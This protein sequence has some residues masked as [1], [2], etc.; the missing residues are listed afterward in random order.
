M[1]EFNDFL[2]DFSVNINSKNGKHRIK[3]EAFVKYPR[4]LIPTCLGYRPMHQ[5]PLPNFPTALTL[6]S[7]TT[8]FLV[9]Q[10]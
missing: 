8:R 1:N 6:T 5:Y 7:A 10:A 2:A 9:S 4:Y 3:S